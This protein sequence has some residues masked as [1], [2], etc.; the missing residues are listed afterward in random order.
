MA[1]ISLWQNPHTHGVLHDNYAWIASVH[2]YEFIF[3]VFIHVYVTINFLLQDIDHLNKSNF[4][5][6][7]STAHSLIRFLA[8]CAFSH[9]CEHK[10]IYMNFLCTIFYALFYSHNIFYIVMTFKYLY[11]SFSSMS[12]RP[13]HICI[14]RFSHSF[15]L[16]PPPAHLSTCC[17]L[18]YTAFSSYSP[19]T[20]MLFKSQTRSWILIQ[21]VVRNC[22]K[23][24]N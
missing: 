12:M 15:F 22:T 11:S 6:R 7:H 21:Y 24:F 14:T 23:L 8:Q 10:L 19:S 9:S 13:H 5:Y 2:E 17:L 3:F 20:V 18:L 4:C 1:L 16:L